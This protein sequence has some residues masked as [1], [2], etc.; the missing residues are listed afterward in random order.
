MNPLVQLGELRQSPWYDQMRR[1]MLTTGE[2]A[3][4]IRE[5]GLKGV[6]SNPTIFEKAI[7]GSTDY[8]DDL[9]RLA[10][11][12]KSVPEIYQALVTADI[13]NAA[14]ALRTVYDQT[15]GEDGYVSLEVAPGLAHETEKTIAEA[16]KLFALLNRP[17]VMIKVP[18][19]PEGIPAIEE[20]IAFGMNINVTL[21]FSQAVY[22]QVMDAYLK[23]LERRAAE[24]KPVDKIASVASFFVSRIDTAAEKQLDAKA[25]TAL[26]E[27]EKGQIASL[28]GKVAIAN[29][30]VAYQ[31]FKKKF[32]GE[33]FDAL[34]AKG[35]RVQRPLWASTG[36]KNPKYSDVLY[37]ENLIGPDTVNTMPP[38]TF[39]A[40]RDHGK[41]ALSL[42]QD[43]QQAADT[44]ATLERA[45][46]S[47]AAITDNLTREGVKLF[48][49]SFDQLMEVIRA[50]SEEARTGVL[51]R[52]T[53]DLGSYQSAVDA[54]LSRMQKENF[55]GRVW[56]KDATLW[57]SDDVHRNIIENAL[58]WLT[59]PDFVLEHIDALKSF[60]EEV[61]NEGFEHAVVLGMGGSS[62][63]PEVFSRIFG[64]IQGYPELLVLDS[65]VPAAI[66]NLEKKIKLDRTLF[67][68]S[69]KSGTTTE[70]VMFHR[71]F[72]DRVKQYREKD[73][74]RQFVAITDPG[75]QLNRDAERDGFRKIFL[76]PPDIGGRYSAL[77]Y[78]GMVPFAVMG[79]A[80]HELLDRSQYAQHACSG[81][82]EAKENPG[83]RLGAVLGT[84][85]NQGRN[86]LTFIATAPIESLGLWTEQLI[87]EST[88]K[89]GKGI[90]PIVGEPLG[91]SEVY[92][93]DRVFVYIHTAKGADPSVENALKALSA[94]GHPVLR[95]VLHDPLDL[96]EE[97]FIW[98]FATAIAG[99]L[100]GIDAFDQPNVQE[101]KDN[102]KR[103]LEEY[104]RNGQL[105]EQEQI[106]EQDGI[107][108]FADS[109]T[110]ALLPGGSLQAVLSA[111]LGRIKPGD[112]VAF[113]EYVEESP[114]YDNLIE[115]FRVAVRDRWKVA[116][117]TGYGPRFLHSTGQL[118]KGGSDQGV[119]LQITCADREDVTIPGEKFTFGVLKSA[120]ALGDYQSL[121]QRHR[122]ALRIDVGTNI[123]LGLQRLLAIVAALAGKSSAA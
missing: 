26:T 98:E 14:D 52:R 38:Q 21:I 91:G 10:K 88:G 49:D 3:R 53:A 4:L 37:I 24:G 50:R 33:R 64:K 96:G 58:G 2:L 56:K 110:K 20:L 16:K 23:G 107:K 45:G 8:A 80:I 117:T 92:V 94:A 5:D 76:N 90:V 89:E 59:V 19:T 30:K 122:R 11:A 67:I 85:A 34:K 51:Q 81:S 70:P 95:H 7:G 29:A 73:P 111:H 18:A 47:L 109:E 84:L 83:A 57:K 60:A 9:R 71:Y 69:S 42:E 66:L 35:A 121:S 79:G 48:S 115:L 54:N 63:C 17:N 101:S 75:T 86:K 61:R 104:T 1:S 72:Y 41:A 46:I 97:F 28:Y 99:A 78:F 44:L 106:V 77:S 13:G 15:H 108:V 93:N 43:L 6:T 65:T 102:T 82:V 22:E 12:G 105:G 40:F 39:E 62:L 36:T 27:E 119:F 123:H 114:E 74:G 120:Q 113:T 112:Y 116:T 100:M 32:A 68:V 118:H 25:K 103:L 31:Q 87:A 55:A